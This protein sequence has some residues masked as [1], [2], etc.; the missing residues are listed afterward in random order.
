MASLISLSC[1]ADSWQEHWTVAVNSCE[2]KRFDEA[3]YHF[4]LAIQG[5]EDEGDESHPHVYVDRARLKMLLNRPD[6]S[7]PDLDRAL[8]NKNIQYQE[9]LRALISRFI[10]R[11]QV[12]M[13]QGALEDL[14]TFGEL[15]VDKPII[16]H[17]KRNIIIR[18]MPDCDCYRKLMTCY[19]IHSGMCESKSNI[20]MLKSGICI[21]DKACDCGCQHCEERDSKDRICD[22]C[23]MTLRATNTA[24]NTRESNCKSYCDQG[25][26]AGAT[27]CGKVFKTWTCQTACGI[28][29]YNIQQGCNWCCE[30]D[31]FY[32]R[33]VK[34]FEDIL[35]RMGEGCDPAWD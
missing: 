35:S 14:K 32:K 17:T 21:V 3:N 19:F 22:A 9:K 18:N 33:C 28:A 24:I 11:A 5:M 6:E 27:W 10:V 13:E 34:P 20:K 2:E 23:G 8:A 1:Y 12:G 16:E 25:A 26:I 30:G 7:L 31:G 15:K 29:V 4:D